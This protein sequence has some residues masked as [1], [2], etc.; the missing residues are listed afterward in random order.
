MTAKARVQSVPH[1]QRSKPQA[2]NTRANGSPDVGERIRLP[3][4]RAGAADLYHRVVS[5]GEFQHLREI[6]PGL[7]RR[8]RNTRLLD[9]QM[10]GQ[11]PRVRVAFYKCYIHIV[12]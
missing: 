12:L 6:G 11:G 7:R 8:R 2:S 1:K 5:L 4:E 10:D 9:G 3:R